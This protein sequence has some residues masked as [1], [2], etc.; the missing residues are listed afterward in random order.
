M[1]ESNALTWSA[2]LA[3]LAR[4]PERLR[5]LL[6]EADSLATGRRSAPDAWSARDIVSHMCAIESPYR[7]RLARIVLEDNPQVAL[8]DRITGGYDPQTPISILLDT[9]ARLRADTLVF[10]RSLPPAAR[11]RPAVHAQFGPITLRGQVASLLEHDREHLAQIAAL[12][13]WDNVIA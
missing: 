10:L 2:L 11:V 8:I 9:F 1:T 12:V 3:E 5:I 13:G 4:T 7:A 6:A